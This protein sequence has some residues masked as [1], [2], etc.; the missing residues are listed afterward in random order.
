LLLPLPL[1]LSLA[2]GSLGRSPGLLLG[3]LLLL[4]CKQLSSGR[5]SAGC[6]CPIRSLCLLRR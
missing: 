3:G 1:P 5:L 2:L 4:R 6:G